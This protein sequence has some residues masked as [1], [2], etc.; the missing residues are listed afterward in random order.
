MHACAGV[1]GSS[2]AGS[3][4]R[5]TIGDVRRSG[6]GPPATDGTVNMP[7]AQAFGDEPTSAPAFWC[8]I[9]HPGDWTLY[10]I[11]ANGVKVEMYEEF[12]KTQYF[13]A[14]SPPAGAAFW[15]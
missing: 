2:N 9:G 4:S 3:A 5:T 15:F 7:A 14:P 13:P 8:W 6:G 10:G 1:F 12:D 11:N